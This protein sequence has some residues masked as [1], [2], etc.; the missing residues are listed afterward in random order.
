MTTVVGNPKKGGNYPTEKNHHVL[1]EPSL[2]SKQFFSQDEKNDLHAK[3]TLTQ[4]MAKQSK[5]AT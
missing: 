1:F 2:S 5:K 4:K 3:F